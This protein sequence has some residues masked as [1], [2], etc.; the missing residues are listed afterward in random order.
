MKIFLF[1]LTSKVFASLISFNIIVG[2]GISNVIAFIANTIND[3]LRAGAKG[4]M[5]AIDEERFE[6]GERFSEQLPQLVELSLLIAAN[7][8]K[9]NAIKNKVWTVNDTIAINR[10]G[11]TLHVQCGWEKARVHGY[12]RQ[13]VESIPNMTY[14]AGDEFEEQ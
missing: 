7:K 13:V 6:Y 2:N 3:A 12:L 1:K 11:T 9:E 4:L 8:T 14:V 10:I 5:K